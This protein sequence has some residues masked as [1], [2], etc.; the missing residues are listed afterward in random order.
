VS[1]VGTY[2]PAGLEDF[3]TPQPIGYMRYHETMALEAKWGSP[4][5]EANVTRPV[6][7]DSPWSLGKDADSNEINAMHEAVVAEITA[8]LTTG[9]T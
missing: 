2:I 9:S 6:D 4:Y 3:P 1:T 7:F 8:N 5:W